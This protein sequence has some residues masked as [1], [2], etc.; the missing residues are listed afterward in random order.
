MPLGTLGD[1]V[2]HEEQAIEAY[3]AKL[4]QLRSTGGATGELSYYSALEALLNAI[5]HHLK[6]KVFCVGQLASQGAGHP[7]F[8][9]Y[10]ANQCQRGE[11]RPGAIPE[12]G[13]VEVKSP[14]DETWLTADTNQVSTYAAHYD[15]VLVTNY[16]A[17][18][19]IGQDAANRPAMLESFILAD[20]D[21]SFWAL[22]A[23]PRKSAKGTALAEYLKRVLT[24]GV[25]LREPKDVAWFLASYGRDALARVEKR[26]DGP[27]L[28]ALKTSLE[29]SLGLRFETDTG[30]HFFHSTLVQTLF[31]G[32]FSAWVLWMREQRQPGRFDWRLAAWYLHVPMLK[33]LFHQLADPEKLKSLDLVEVLDWTAAALNRVDAAEFFKRFR[34]AEAVQHF[35]EPFLEAFDPQL[36]RQ[37][38]V[39][40]TPPEVVAYMVA[41]V[42]RALR[43][44]LGVADE[45]AAEHVYVLDPCAGT[46]AFLVHVLDRIARTLEDRGLGALKAEK[47]KQAA[48]ARVF[49]FEIMPA[50]F[51]VAHLQIGLYLRSIDAPLIDQSERAGIF[52]TNALTGWE[53]ERQRPKLP[54][55]ELAEERE[56]AAQVKQATPILVVLGNPPYNGFA[57]VAIDEERALTDAYRRVRRVRP[58]EGQGL[59]D[60]YVRFY[61]MAERRIV[62]ATG[63]GIVSFIS[64]YSWLDGLSFTGMRERFLEV[65]DVIRIDC[66]NGDKYK[67]GKVTP[68]GLPDPSI[69]STE[70]NREGIQVG[71][72][73]SLLVR[74][75]AHQPT[76]VVGFRHL[77]G[78]AKRQELTA[79]AADAPEALYTSVAP[80][81]PL[82]LPFLSSAVEADYLTWPRLPDLFPVS[83][84][85]VKTSRDEFLVDIDRDALMRRLELY[86]DPAGSHEE[87]RRIA[88]TVMTSTPRFKAEQTR[89]GLRSRGFLPGNVIRYC[90]RPFDIRW[91]YWEPDTKLLDEKRAEYRPHVFNGNIC[92]EARERQPKEEFTRGGLCRF[93]ADNM[94]NGLSNFFPLYLRDDHAEPDEHGIGK[95]LNLT[96]SAAARMAAD[97]LAA[98]DLFFH[99]IVTLHAPA[100]RRENAGALRM[101]WPRLPFPLAADALRVSAAL[102][103]RLAGLLDPE[104]P[105]AGVTAGG[106]RPELG[107]IAVPV[108]TGGV[109][110][111]EAERAV[112]AGWGY[113]ANGAVM[114]GQG[115][116]VARAYTQAE[117]DK[118]GAA[119]DLLGEQTFDVRLNAEAHWAN[120]P[121]KV[122]AY[123]LGG[124]PVLKKWLSYR[125][126]NVL[127][128][129]LK[130]DEVQY[131]AEVARRIAA[132]L[133]LGPALDAAYA[134]AK[135]GF[136]PT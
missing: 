28:I 65:F 45:L 120:I 40:Y 12:R 5:G 26:A 133:L 101:D 70:H 95:R 80:Q 69:F 78:V 119:T 14:K 41:R 118:L 66:L 136:A 55:P 124:Y 37:L 84:P 89:E 100:Y 50:P 114:P 19:L 57:G 63:K 75:T 1:A 32:V 34:D 88:P 87:M 25:A 83:F 134:A 126:R 8:G 43:E 111:G 52:L 112:T 47:V 72:A 105:V 129:P 98:E 128:R 64:N 56:R 22:T 48:M 9:L 44:D 60:L 35:Y 13:V 82:G 93:L 3:L 97:G 51:V 68:D 24:H 107:T 135:A 2:S 91:L 71:T 116:A 131:F 123:T 54:F 4:G 6:P 109:G 59:N 113:R 127:G 21:A 33:A 110:L 27:A 125:E 92:I 121:G 17:F 7:D 23:A 106:L 53:P 103:R 115:R 85:G 108:R 132:I 77:W 81:V 90:Y 11:P 58:P 38:G 94:G 39:W 86:F 20:S 61:R 10:T 42:D 36:R 30:L 99:A 79:T 31:Y 73:I 96:A 18:L 117:R 46:G 49:G 122:W 104:T 76:T 15:T 29:D 102:G 130:V 67:T 74:K 62:E 16:R